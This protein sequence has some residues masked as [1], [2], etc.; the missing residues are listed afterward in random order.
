MILQN[1]GHTKY[2]H[3]KIASYLLIEGVWEEW[4]MRD[5]HRKYRRLYKAVKIR[6][7][8]LGQILD[9]SEESAGKVFRP[10]LKHVTLSRAFL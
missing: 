1:K 4:V 5:L 2:I 9:C 3:T 10:Q 6:A 8:A 7:I